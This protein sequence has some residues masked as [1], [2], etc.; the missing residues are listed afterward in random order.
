[1]HPKYNLDTFTLAAE[2]IDSNNGTQ[3]AC[4][5]LQIVAGGKFAAMNEVTLFQKTFGIDGFGGH[6]TTFPLLAKFEGWRPFG[7]L[8]WEELQESRVLA[9][10][11]VREIARQKNRQGGHAA[12]DRQ[13]AALR[14]V[15]QAVKAED[16]RITKESNKLPDSFEDWCRDNRA[17]VA[18][19]TGW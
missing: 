9:L 12:R 17:L 18:I 4:I 8:T 15:R 13:R 14:R 1:M 6:V 2:L 11:L 7:G 5:A 10:L 16:E 3:F 19:H